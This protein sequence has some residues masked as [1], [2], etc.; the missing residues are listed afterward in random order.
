MSQVDTSVNHLSN[1]TM[2]TAATK[3]IA[4][5]VICSGIKTK[6]KAARAIAKTSRELNLIFSDNFPPNEP[7]GECYQTNS[8]NGKSKQGYSSHFSSHTSS[9]MSSII[10]IF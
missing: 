6:A 7:K 3:S 1:I 2:I 5:A 4:A 9:K 10:D 8:V